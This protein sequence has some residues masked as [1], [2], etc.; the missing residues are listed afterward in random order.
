[1]KKL[2]IVFLSALSFSIASKAQTISTIA[3]I[4]FHGYSGD[5]GPATDAELELPSGINVDDSGNVFIADPYAWSVRK[6][7]ASNGIIITAIGNGTAGYS[8]DGGQ[9]TAAELDGTSKITFDTSGNM[10]IVDNSLIRKVILSTGVINTVAGGYYSHNYG[11]GGPATDARIGFSGVAVDD[12]GNIYIADGKDNTIRKVTAS[13]GIIT[14]I[15][16]IPGY[17]G[18]SGDGGPAT[19]A[20][21]YG[22][23]GIALDKSGYIY[24]ADA[25]NVVIRKIDL[26]TGIISTVAGNHNGG[27]SGDGGSATSAELRNPLDVC[28]DAQ[29]N[30]YISDD[31]NSVVRMVNGTTGIITTV[32]GI[33]SGGYSGDGGLATLAE[34]NSPTGVHIDPLGNLYI[35]DDGN[36]NVRKVSSITTAVNKVMSESSDV[37][38]YPNPTNGLFTISLSHANIFSARQTI[39]VY[40]VLGQPILTETIHYPQNDKV[41]NLSNQPNGVYFYRVV[42]QFG[43]LI[44]EGKLIISR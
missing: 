33:G 38:V 34:L 22:P 35:T 28:L 18:Y 13:N 25:Q 24:V 41:I 5:G 31:G 21:L 27:Y 9:A 4:Y 17:N 40:N 14:T 29:G 36:A 8:G 6:I 16:G 15:A 42:T 39:I 3:G 30:F 43:N 23:I 7:F 19:A 2:T 44:G 26:S 32:A 1:M 20:E 37:S 12:S 10:Y 11:D